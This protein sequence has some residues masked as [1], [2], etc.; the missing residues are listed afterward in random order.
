MKRY[1]NRNIIIILALS[2][3]F[4]TSCKQLVIRIDSFPDNTPIGQ[5]IYVTGNFNNWDPGEEIYIMELG[6]DSNY[7]ITLPP[8]FGSVEYKFTRGDWTTVEKGICGEEL[9]NRLSVLALTDTISATIES[10][11]DLDP[12]DCPKLIIKLENVPAN[13]PVDD[14][15]AIASNTN[16]WDPDDASVFEE[17]TYGDL[18][19]TIDRPPEINMLEYKITRGNLSTSE[20]DEFGNELPNRILEFG[21]KDTVKISVEGWADLPDNKPNRVIF[22]IRDLPK[23]T[24]PHDKLILVSNL[25]SWDAGDMN[26]Q[27]QLNKNGQL[28]YPVPRKK[29]A[30]EYKI[31]RGDW[32]TQEVDKNGYHIANR[33]TNLQ[34]TDTVYI[35]IERWMDIGKPETDVLTI[36]LEEIPESTPENAKL[37]LAVDFNGWD[38][39]KLRHRFH[40]NSNGNYYVNLPKK[41]H[42]H[43]EMRVTRGSWES[44]QI[45]KLGSEIPACKYH[46]SDPDTIM[47][48]VENWKDLPTTNTNIVTLVINELPD[49]TR[50]NDNIFLAPDFNG[51]DPE[52]E[53]LIFDK[54]PNGRPVISFQHSEKSMEYKITR[55]GWYKVEVDKNGYETS[56]RILH[57]GFA[58]TVFIDVVKWRDF[59]GKY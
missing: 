20:S 52:D 24:P 29:S 55:G 58:D 40:L 9:D 15:I 19:V 5:Q 41:E 33:I 47:L 53:N 42:N 34:T 6:S 13:T 57:F 43:I 54:L 35:D 31:T 44:A 17:N 59:G 46:F 21:K 48:K 27:F 2:M 50:I 8:G 30:L 49:E 25:N 1:I 23:N 11:N 3:L 14:I 39:G 22:I 38:P 16:S 18:F 45:G 10:W 4:M 51:W 36:V 12:L 32:E 37:Y 7:Y 26:Y 28:F 56:N